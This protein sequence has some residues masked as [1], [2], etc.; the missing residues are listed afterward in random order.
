MID[1]VYKWSNGMVMVFDA[2]G[3]QIPE[4]QGNYEDVKDAILRD[5]PSDALFYHA[6]WAPD[7]NCVPRDKW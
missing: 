1:T 2:K 4:Y 6:A 5:A 7:Q 3:E